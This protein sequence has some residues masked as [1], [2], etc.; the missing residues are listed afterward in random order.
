M[1]TTYR[2]SCHPIP[3]ANHEEHNHEEFNSPLPIGE[4]TNRVFTPSE[5]PQYG[6]PTDPPSEIV[7]YDAKKQF[8]HLR[9]S[10]SYAPFHSKI[11]NDTLAISIYGKARHEGTTLAQA[12]SGRHFGPDSELNGALCSVPQTVQN[13]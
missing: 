6:T 10:N 12:V 7:V 3:S 2:L 9:H 11:E 4:R 1:A 13:V 5:F 8:S